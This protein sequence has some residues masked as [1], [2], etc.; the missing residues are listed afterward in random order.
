M[1]KIQAIL[2]DLDGTL[3][4]ST[5]LII[6]SFKHVVRKQF[7]KDISREELIPNF[8]KPLVEAMEEI[9]PGQGV[10]LVNLYREYTKIHHDEMVKI[11]PEVVET[12]E[13]LHDM[14]IK[15]GIVTSKVRQTALRGLQLFNLDHLFQVFVGYEDTIIHKPKPEPVL[16]ALEKLGVKAENAIMVGDSPHDIASARA[17]GTR[18]VAVTWSSFPLEVLKAEQPSYMIN[19]MTELIDLVSGSEKYSIKE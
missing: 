10:L 2:F 12:L 6:S 17:A 5:D 19:S 18:T 11:F 16:Y 15:L 8:G 14:N 4:D 13:K 1:S 9:A 3:L 7:N